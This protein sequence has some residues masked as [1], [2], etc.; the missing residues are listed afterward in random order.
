MSCDR[1][2]EICRCKIDSGET[3]CSLKISQ[4]TE[5][6]LHQTRM[7]KQKEQTMIEKSKGKI[8]QK[9]S[10]YDRKI[11]LTNTWHQEDKTQNTHRTAKYN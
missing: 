6:I 4:V 8:K 9:P 1:K 11:P 5:S 2:T 3:L 10:E 7:Y